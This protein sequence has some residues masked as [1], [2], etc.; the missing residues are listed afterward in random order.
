MLRRLRGVDVVAVEAADVGLRV[1][2]AVEVGVRAGMASETSRTGI[3]GAQF[4]EAANLGDIAT[5]LHVGLTGSVAAFARHALAGMFESET[6]MGIV[7]EFLRDVRVTSGAGILTD[8]IR[9]VGCRLR[10]GS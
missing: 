4:V 3:F 10:L 7:S 8:E 9:R 6:G 2:G 1:R 5:A